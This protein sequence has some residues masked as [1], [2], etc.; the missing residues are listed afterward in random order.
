MTTRT[1]F[2]P[3][4]TGEP[5]IGNVRT[6]LFSWLTARHAA[7]GKF[8]LRIEDTDQERYTPGSARV[9]VESLRWLGVELDEGPDHAQLAAMKTN[10]DWEGA[11]D[12]SGPYAPYVQSQRLDLYRQHTD[13]LIAN[14]LAYRANETAEE[15]ERMRTAAQADKRAFTFRR[16]MRLRE[17]IR[18]D[19]PHV[20]RFAMPLTG[21][22]T[23]DDMI[24][25]KVTFDNGNLD[26]VVLLKSDGFPTY[27]LAAMVD[28][29]LMKVSHVVRAVEWLPSAPKHLR[30]IEAFGWQPPRFAHV[31]LVLSEDGKKLSKRHGATSVTEFREQGYLP[32]ALVN[33]LAMLGWA[34]GQ[35]DEQNVFTREELF[36]KFTLEKVGASP[37]IF[38]YAK[39]DWLNGVHIRRLAPDDLARRLVP[40]LARGGVQIDTPD[41]LERLIRL[42]PLVQV[43]IDRLT[44]AAELVDIFFNDIAT[45]SSEMLIGPKM[46]QHLSLAALRA[47]RSALAALSAWSEPV[48]ESTLRDLGVALNLKPTQLFTVIRNAVS[49][50]Q[51]TPPL[52]GMLDA[53]GRDITLERLD[54]AIVRLGAN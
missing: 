50:K 28:D 1:R 24:Q 40:F 48:I 53:L 7:D 35:G 2:A 18:P 46:E 31:P 42:M 12:V 4:P 22:T 45:P 52:F 6:M 21:T 51:V 8:F 26:D 11:A 23:L 29:H 27:H 30:I 37:A 10:E 17:D 5:H 44:K 47:T 36:E 16:H 54:R 20:V 43:R 32:E 15:L 14:G 9:I 34:P 3:S 19:E 39:L 41:K 38:S 13:L 25:G 33:F 49:G